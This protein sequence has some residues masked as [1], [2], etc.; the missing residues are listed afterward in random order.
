ML[1]LVMGLQEKYSESKYALNRLS[2]DLVDLFVDW[3]I[4]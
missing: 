2:I 4:D 1:L 3:L